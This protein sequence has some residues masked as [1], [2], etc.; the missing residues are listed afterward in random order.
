MQGLLL[1]CEMDRFWWREAWICSDGRPPSTQQRSSCDC[2][3]L[4]AQHV[5][6]PAQHASLP[7]AA[8]PKAPLCWASWSNPSWVLDCQRV[9]SRC[10]G[11]V[12]PA[13]VT[14]HVV[15]KRVSYKIFTNLKIDH[16]N[17]HYVH[18]SDRKDDAPVDD[19][20]WPSPVPIRGQPRPEART[21]FIFPNQAICLV[22]ARSSREV[23][24]QTSLIQCSNCNPK[25]Q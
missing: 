7:A 9:V 1:S 2:A 3:L 25:N 13:S 21:V 14:W 15:L 8:E 17:I 4:R 11:R 24:T 16:S 20:A 19:F 23:D 5:I 6:E 18:Y 22:C 12:V 10:L